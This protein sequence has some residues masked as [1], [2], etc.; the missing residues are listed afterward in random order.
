ME[1]SN[2]FFALASLLNRFPF[3]KRH[4]SLVFHICKIHF[5]L[6]SKD[7]FTCFLLTG[8]FFQNSVYRQTGKTGKEM[9]RDPVFA[10]YTDSAL[11]NLL[12]LYGNSSQICRLSSLTRRIFL[13]GHSADSCRQPVVSFFS[14]FFFIRIIMYASFFAIFC[15]CDF[16]NKSCR[17]VWVLPLFFYFS[18]RHHFSARSVCF[19]R[20]GLW[21]SAYLG[22]QV[23]I[24]RG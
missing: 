9:C 3:I 15:C 21:Y 22:E 8:I 11:K 16:S 6:S 5:F 1:Y 17:I 4:E 14:N 19:S 10:L 18:V 7:F 13:P 20:I 23:M 2:L 12:P 24:R